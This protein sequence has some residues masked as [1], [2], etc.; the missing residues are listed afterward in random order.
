MHV[1]VT[2]TSTERIDPAAGFPNGLSNDAG[3]AR[4]RA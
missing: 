3:V 1:P 4:L 2:N